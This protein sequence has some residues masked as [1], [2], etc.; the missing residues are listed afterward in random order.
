[1]NG[2]NLPRFYPVLD[3]GLLARRGI[4]PVGAAEAVLDAV[5]RILQLRQKQHF[6]RDVFRD[7]TQIAE[8]CRNA[9]ALFVVND[10]ADMAL[11]LDA[12]LHIG[13]D[14]LPPCAARRVIGSRRAIGF[15]THNE[16]QLRDVQGEPVDYVAFGPMFATASK[17]NPDPVVGLAELQRLRPLSPRP[18]VAIGGITR[19]TAGKVLAAGADSVA[20][21]SDLIPEECTPA[22]L[23]ART[24]EWVHLLEK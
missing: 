20:I 13:Q 11:M 24:E 18:L 22:R 16:R 9:G 15:S 19:A 21:I 1:M 5:S 6:S 10:R 4:A 8:L 23:R 12:A 17:D 7:A 14:D 2:L 3:T